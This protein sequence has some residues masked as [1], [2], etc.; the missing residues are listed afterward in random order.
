[1]ETLGEV[2]RG[3]RLIEMIQAGYLRTVRTNLAIA[4]TGARRL[5]SRLFAG[6]VRKDG[7]PYANHLARV[8]DGVPAELKPAAWL[9][10]AMEDVGAT[11]ESLAAEGIDA[12]TIELV[13]ILTRRETETYSEFIERI[14]ADRDAV[15]VKLSDLADNMTDGGGPSDR[16]LV[17]RYKAAVERLAPA[18]ILV[19][20]STD[21]QDT[22]RQVAELREVATRNGWAVVEVVE[23]SG[24]SGASTARPGLARIEALAL[25]GRIKRVLVHEVSR[26][27]R[28][29]AIV[30]A[31][32]ERLHDRGV[33]IYWH[34]QR[35]ETL[36]PSGSRNPAAGMMLAIL[37]EMA[38]AER[39]TLTA[40]IKSGLDQARRNGRT[41]GRPSGSA[42]DRGEFL[43][44]HAD[45][46]ALL[47]RGKSVRDVAS[48]VRKSTAT[49]QK[50]RALLM[51]TRTEEA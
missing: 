14:A 40:R 27:G 43:G 46:V 22:A 2:Y 29:P 45:V 9:H 18:A 12:R 5:A 4:E 23:E 6:I 38:L 10:D 3:N 35:V 49:V 39:E 1:M 51:S 50:V 33:S 8:A 21:K 28:R 47:Q 34:A 16:R 48:R 37:A 32:V 24:I 41:L 26:I 19:R 44:K 13:G 11:A 36:L 15:T 20:V 42:E 17:A 30:H 25:E 7:T 31:F